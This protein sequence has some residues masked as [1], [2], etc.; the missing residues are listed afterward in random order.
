MMK[1]II[2]IIFCII[3]STLIYFTRPMNLSGQEFRFVVNPE[4]KHDSTVQRLKNEGFIRSVGLFN[5]LTIFIKPFGEIE[6]GA[7]LLKKNMTIFTISITVLT[8]PYQKWA[9]IV[10]GLRKEQIAEK[11]AEKFNWN[12]EKRQEF[13]QNSREGYMFPDTYLLNVDYT[14]KE[15]ADRLISNFNEKFDAKLQNDLLAQDVRN[16][17]AIKIAS[18]IERE[19]GGEEDKALIAGIIWNRLNIGMK[20][21]IDATS[22]YIKGQPGNWWPKITPADHKQ[23]SLYNTYIY[24]GLPP[25]PICSPS[26][27]SIKAAVYPADTECLFYIHDKNKQ[28]HCAA[29]YREHLENIE[30]YLK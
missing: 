15:F 2:F 12:E 20:L 25:A 4:E 7:Y 27:A 29:T 23:D 10:P 13:L 6:P 1:K 30:E 3:F 17:T 18:L 21:Q 9:V 28:I 24:K 22:Q 16:D 26:L 5:L 8:N 19:S 11:L 14:G